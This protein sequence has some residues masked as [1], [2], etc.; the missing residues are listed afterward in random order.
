[1]F[2]KLILALALCAVLVLPAVAQSPDLNAAISDLGHRWAAANYTT[3][4][5]QKDAAMKAV[6]TLAQKAAKN[7]PDK[8]EPL[9]WQSIALASA[10]QIEGGF[11]AL[12]KARQARELLLQAE[13]INPKAVDGSIYTTLGSLYA[14]VPGWP[15]SYGNKSKAKAFLLKALSIDPTGID[16]NYFYA[17]FLANQG[18]YAQ[19]AAYLK[20]ALDAPARPGRADADAGRREDAHK[21][22]AKLMHDHA[23]KLAKD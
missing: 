19:S 10:A 23:D 12:S 13:A 21:L 15:I 9:V 16:A 14:N 3:P 5:G 22:L 4:Q 2:R 8:A 17:D 7:F 1:M 11:S 6:V 20:K 18:D